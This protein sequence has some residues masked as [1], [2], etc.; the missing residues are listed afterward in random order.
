MITIIDN[1]SSNYT[2]QVRF[3]SQKNGFPSQMFASQ[4]VIEYVKFFNCL[5][6]TDEFKLNLLLLHA[7]LCNAYFSFAIDEYKSG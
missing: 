6:R 7:F 4:Q 5:K 3:P 2:F 1:C